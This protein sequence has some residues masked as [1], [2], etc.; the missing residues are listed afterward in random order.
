MVFNAYYD[1]LCHLTDKVYLKDGS[2]TVKREV[3][4][5]ERLCNNFV[6]AGLR[7]PGFS[8]RQKMSITEVM[9]EYGHDIPLSPYSA[10]WPFSVLGIPDS[11]KDSDIDKWMQIFDYGC[12]AVTEQSGFP[13]TPSNVLELVKDNQGVWWIQQIE[14]WDDADDEEYEPGTSS[15]SYHDVARCEEQMVEA[16]IHRGWQVFFAMRNVEYTLPAE[17]DGKTK[18][19]PMVKKMRMLGCFEP[20]GRVPPKTSEA[21]DDIIDVARKDRGKWKR[22]IHSA[23]T[24]IPVKSLTETLAELDIVCSAEDEA[25]FQHMQAK[26]RGEYAS[27]SSFASES[28][29][30]PSSGVDVGH[31]QGNMMGGG[32]GYVTGP[33]ETSIVYGEPT[34][35]P[36]VGA[37]AFQGTGRTVGESSPYGEPSVFNTP[38]SAMY[39]AYAAGT[40]SAPARI[41]QPSMDIRMSTY[42]NHAS[43]E[44]LPFADIAEKVIATKSRENT[45]MHGNHNVDPFGGT[46]SKTVDNANMRMGRSQR[47]MSPV[48]PGR[49]SRSNSPTKS[50]FTVHTG[51]RAWSPVRKPA[52]NPWGAIG[53]PPRRPTADN[54]V[55]TAPTIP[56]DNEDEWPTPHRGS[57]RGRRN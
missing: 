2:S 42:L 14:G 25:A 17:G 8:E 28:S 12:I 39:N 22:L 56:E 11:A 16:I 41:K 44:Q 35:L 7:C 52:T 3:G 31:T 20:D 46:P 26:I 43:G 21:G 38:S 53:T 15:L 57:T 48:R 5:T 49:R 34:A 19:T 29:D 1:M 18:D 55:N 13:W 37:S 32:P 36:Q 50:S 45:P 24:R 54:T 33:M 30:S 23:T 9:N 27:D 51:S 40:F 6:N 4:L 47:Q 10:V